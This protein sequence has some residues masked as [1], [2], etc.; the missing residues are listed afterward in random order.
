[1]AKDMD[2]CWTR[3]AVRTEKGPDDIVTHVGVVHLHLENDPNLTVE[4]VLLP[5]EAVTLGERLMVEGKAA[6]ELADLANKPAAGM[7]KG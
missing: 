1:M 7:A 6:E 5:M 2:R 4:F 3:H